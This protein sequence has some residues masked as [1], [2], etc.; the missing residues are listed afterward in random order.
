MNIIITLPIELIAEIAEGRKQV[1]IRKSIPHNFNMNHDV[2]WVKTKGS[3]KVPMCFEISYF[4]EESDTEVVWRRYEDLICVPFAWYQQYV[5]KARRIAIWHIKRVHMFMP[6]LTF[7][8]T[9]EGIKAPQ[10][11]VYT[12]VGLDSIMHRIEQVDFFETDGITRRKIEPKK[13]VQ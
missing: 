1:E 4:D 7:S 9:F 2:V 6:N 13:A 3:D 12:K 8:E 5:R 10:S 11:F